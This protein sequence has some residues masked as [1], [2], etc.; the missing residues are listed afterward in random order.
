MN[1]TPRTPP[2][3]A[4]PLAPAH[5]SSQQ[6]H[7]ILSQARYFSG[8]SADVLEQVSRRFRELHYP[9]D[10]VICHEG[11]AAERLY[12]VAHGKV[13]LLRHSAAGDDVL[14]DLLPQGALFGGLAPLGTRYCS[15]TAVAQTDAC[16]LAISGADFQQMLEQHPQVTLAV[17]ASV[18]RSLDDAREAIRQIT[19]S[20]VRTRVATALLKLAERLG[21]DGADGV[22]GVLIR[23]PLSRQDLAAM[24]GATPETVSRVMADLKREGLLDSGRQWVRIVDP[25]GLRAISV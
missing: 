20:D 7:D 25:R 9:A 13:K 23:S 1:A 6:R 15:E 22:D 18:A 4:D 10:A 24:I 17:L 19:T 8:L 12:F 5:C 21:E 14:L 3:T 16:V 11:D 2:Q